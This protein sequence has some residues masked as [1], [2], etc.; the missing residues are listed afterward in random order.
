MGTATVTL[1][2]PGSGVLTVSENGITVPAGPFA[3]TSIVSSTQGAISL[4]AGS[5]TLAA[6]GA[7]TW[8]IGLTF[9]PTATGLFQV[10][11]TIDSNDP[12]TPAATVSLLGTGMTP[13]ASW[14][15]IRCRRPM[16]SR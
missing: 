11:L 8:T 12:N 2:D 16:T 5:K 14:S 15:P 9:D 10:P 7:E 6:G 3:I 1:S 4:A 13:P